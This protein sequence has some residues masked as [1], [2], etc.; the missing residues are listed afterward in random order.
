MPEI[1]DEG[2]TGWTYDP[3][4]DGALRER[5]KR[6]R[7]SPERIPEMRST[8]WKKA[9]NYEVAQHAESYVE[10]YN[11][12]RGLVIAQRIDWGWKKSSA[13]RDRKPPPDFALRI[14]ARGKIKFKGSMGARE[15]G[16]EEK[17][18]RQGN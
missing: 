3:D 13:G 7:S 1:V 5:I 10:V 8:V 4:D 11:R 12:N 9:Q 18:P 2:E 15:A 16:V 6:L 14:D 17:R